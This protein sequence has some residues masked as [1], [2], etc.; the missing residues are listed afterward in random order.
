MND[1][2]QDILFNDEE[3]LWQGKPKK[4]CYVLQ[5]FGRLLPAAIIFLLF[6]SFF[7]G[8]TVASGA[9]K[10]M[11][12]FLVVFFAFHLIPVWLCI[13]KIVTSNLEHKN[14]VYAV[15]SRR[16][17]TRTGIVG[18]D[19]EAIDYA[20]VSNVNVNVS[21]IERM[22]KV[23]TVIVSTSSGKSL[24][25]FSVDDPYGLYK[26]VNKVFVDMKAD[27]HY[28]NALRPDVNPGYNTKYTG[29]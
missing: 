27:V 15:T 11:W 3:V 8:T 25:L 4:L 12:L 16:I 18:L 5:S 2:L 13:G 22:F 20:D 24:R 9:F 10:E 26:K 29:V 1:S 23:G 19:F 7:I 21:V 28:P 17:I 14:I 6:D